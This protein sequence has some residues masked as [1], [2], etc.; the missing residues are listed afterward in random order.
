M[1]FT[2]DQLLLIAEIFETALAN[3]NFIDTTSGGG[4]STE[5]ATELEARMHDVWWEARAQYSGVR[6]YLE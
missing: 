1:A 4:C 3:P 2:K 6:I 5:E